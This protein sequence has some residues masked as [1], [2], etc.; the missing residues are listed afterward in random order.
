MVFVKIDFPIKHIDGNLIFSH[1]GRVWAFYKVEGFNYDFL[2]DDEKMF[3]FHQQLS[4]VANIGL[5]LHYL[6]IPHPTDV[7]GI[8][9][10]TI[11]EM[12]LKDY[13][14]KENGISF[15]EQVK[16]ALEN[17]KEL[18]ESSEYHDYI[19]IQ[20]D[21]KKNKYVSGNLGLSMISSFKEFLN[22]LNSP[23]YQAVGLYPDDILESEIQAYRSQASTIETTLSSAFSSRVR[24]VQTHEIVYI[25]EKFFS[26][27]NNNSDVVA[28]NDFKTGRLVE[29]TDKDGKK[30]KAIRNH[31]KE[32]VDLQNASIEEINPRELVVSRINDKN[33]IE[34]LYVQHLVIA[35]MGDVHYHPGFE[36]LYHIKM[37]MPFPVTISVR[38]DHEPNELVKKR[39][40][41]TKLEIQDQRNE[42]FKGGQNIDLSVAASEE[43]TIRMENYFTQTGFPGFACSFVMKVTGET[44]EQLRT[45]VELLRNELAKFGIK[46]LSPYGEQVPLFLEMIPG[47]RKVHEDYRI[48]VSPE[49]LAAMMFGATTNIGD[50]RG[51]YIGHTSKLSKPVFVQPDLAAK[52]FEGLGNKVDSISVLV[53]GMTGKGKSFFMNLY[54]YLSTLTGSKGLI[55]DPKGDR[56]G[57]AEGLP[58]IPKEYISVW[59]LGTDP[60]DAGSLDP[61]RTSTSIEEGKDIAM[62]ILSY[63]AQISIDDVAY[64]ILSEAVEEASTHDDPCIGVVIDILKRMYDNRDET[65]TQS[66]YEALEGL[67]NTLTTLK[68]NQLSML[69]FGE[70]GQNYKVLQHDKPIQVLMIQ[71]LRLPS[72]DEQTKRPI[73]MI[74]EAIMIS[75][76]AWTKQYM[77]N[78]DRTTHKYILQDE[79]SA[80]E[81]S[82]IGSELMDFIVRMGRYYNTTLLK[83]S[84]NASD[85]GK[86]VANIGMKFSFALRKTDEAEQMLDYLNLPVTSENVE[87][88]KKLDRGECLFQDIYGRSA[89][90]RINPVFS[91]LLD[92]FDS[93][94]STKEEREREKQRVM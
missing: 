48:E 40:T 62:D 93:S 80:I 87:K 7:V 37:Q 16:K 15:M 20:L 71:N 45:R 55:I 58:L 3:P 90:I 10:N 83:G 36:W 78:S 64:S 47:S 51:F 18:N 42:A 17:Q 60:N 41:N 26:T 1:D 69:L 24:K 70:V 2:D 67:L 56:K 75:I 29:G 65:M 49:I 32:F 11:A 13:P 39:L 23:V 94:T 44:E 89:I 52:A 30:Y 86:D 12:K 85:H 43:G 76:T 73:H 84:Q 21:K 54:I 50:N 25:I 59:T 5:D 68:R 91:D 22:G 82:P 35:D 79:A 63:L 72:H 33:E 28:R 57:W 53:A 27:R 19:G 61:F 74:S 14:L 46:I 88:L 4:F 9:N 34:E 77:F 81:R 8:I 6:S 38:A 92:A 31:K 66:R